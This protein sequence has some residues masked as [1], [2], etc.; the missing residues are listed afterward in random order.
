M[1]GRRI[2]AAVLA[3]VVLIPAFVVLVG[4]AALTVAYAVG[5]DDEGFF[6]TGIDG[7]QTRTAAV[8]SDDIDLAG[9]P[10]PPGWLVELGD[11]TVELRLESVRSDVPIFVGV[12]PQVEVEEYLSGVAHEEVTGLD[13]HR[14]ELRT[15]FGTPDASPPGDETFWEASVEGVG[16]QALRWEVES[17]RWVV[18]VMNADGS[19]GVSA[20]VEVAAKAGFLLPL[21]ITMLAAGGLITIATVTGIVL[22]ARRPTGPATAPATAEPV[23]VHAGPVTVGAELDEPLS[24][25]LWLVKWF[26]AIPHFVVL[27]FLWLAFVVLTVIAGVAILFTRRYPRGIFDFNVGVLRW[28]WRVSYYALTGGLGTD[29]YPPFSL[30]AEP[31]YPATLDIAVPEDLSRGLVLVKWWLLAIPHYLVLA[32]MAGW[33]VGWGAEGWSEPW[34]WSGGLLGILALIAG[35]SLLFR[36]SYPQGLFDL[37]IGLNRWVFRVIAYAALMTDQYPPFRLDQGG[38]EP[39]RSPRPF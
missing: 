26:L 38:P 33:G 31:D 29:Q 3:V 7:L 11:V 32:M 27:V 18:V 34:L 24:P 39:D 23:A 16:P 5:R 9:D 4:G 35:A 20:D 6:D 22:L 13:G 36:N 30:G 8:A 25:W 37:I 19:P 14:L 10:G 2:A 17:G 28:S 21:A 12:G 15:R 1:T